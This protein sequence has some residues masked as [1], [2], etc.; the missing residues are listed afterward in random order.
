MTLLLVRHGESAGNARRLIQGWHEFPL[1]E[2]GHRQADAVSRRLA[3]AGAVAL[4][5]SPILRAWQ[6]AAPIAAA[7]GLT[8]VRTDGLREYGSGEAEGLH[9]QE[10]A[11]RWGL[12]GDDWGVGRVPGE[13]GFEAF[14]DRVAQTVETLAARHT[15]VTPRAG[16]AL[17]DTPD[18]VLRG[19]VLRGVV[20]QDRSDS[21]RTRERLRLAQ[22]ELCHW[23]GLFAPIHAIAIAIVGADAWPTERTAATAVHLAVNME[24]VGEGRFFAVSARNIH[25]LRPYL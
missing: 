18:D 3:G 8:P 22:P 23:R 4:Y 17:G 14:R 5:A 21:R 2:R 1:T 13:E 10:A 7:T 11:T 24:R 9:W 15:G 16:R 20:V 19:V 25:G 12:S 6:T